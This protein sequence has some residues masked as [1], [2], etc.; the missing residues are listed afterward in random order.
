MQ[1]PHRWAWWSLTGFAAGCWLWA[2]LAVPFSSVTVSF[3][4]LLALIEILAVGCAMARVD[5]HRDGIEVRNPFSR[6]EV[7]WDQIDATSTGR[8]LAFIPTA[9]VEVA[10][11]VRPLFAIQHRGWAWESELGASAPELQFLREQVS[12]R[13]LGEEEPTP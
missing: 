3:T 5:Y 1:T 11:R 9:R 10:G 4:V 7:R 8:Y 13:R 6:F 2:L 12:R